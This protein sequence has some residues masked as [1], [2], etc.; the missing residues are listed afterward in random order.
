MHSY[1]AETVVEQDGR[2]T[3]SKVP[4][5]KGERV[6]VVVIPAREAAE[7]AENEAWSRLAIESFFRDYDEKDSIYDTY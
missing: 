7:G 3:L 5:P 2:V 1:H 4:F 6:E